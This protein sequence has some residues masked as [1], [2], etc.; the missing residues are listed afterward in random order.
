M[1]DSSD[2]VQRLVDL[3]GDD[4]TDWTKLHEDLKPFYEKK[5]GKLKWPMLRSPLVYQVPFLSW[6]LANESYLAKKKAVSERLAQGNLAGA[7]FF[8]ER[9]YRLS[10]IYEWMH[11][12][13]NVKPFFADA[14]RDTELPDSVL[15]KPMYRE[16][17]L[18][19]GFLTDVEGL[20]FADLPSHVTVYRGSQ[21][22]WRRGLAWSR[23]LQTAQFF[24]NRFSRD[25]YKV[26]TTT[27][28]KSAILAWLDG[29]GEQEVVL[30]PRKIKVVEEVV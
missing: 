29:R 18:E 28:P 3:Y 6:K 19:L 17:F 2:H 23:S 13:M 21:F 15:A 5:G 22:R 10:I 30:H 8:Y 25:G 26:W 11:Q 4:P 14:W 20:K 9:P 7:C 1:S 16:M 27:V 24:A 12:G